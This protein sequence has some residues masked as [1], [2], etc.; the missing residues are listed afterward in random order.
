MKPVIKKQTHYHLLLLR[1]DR[2]VLS[3]RVGNGLVRWL[4]ILGLCLA[5]FGSLGFAAGYHFWKENAGLHAQHQ[6]NEI[7]LARTRLQLEQ[8]S[9]V[10]SLLTATNTSVPLPK[11]EEVSVPA[12]V[13]QEASFARMNGTANATAVANA[14][15]ATARP[16][17]GV[18]ATTRLAS[19]NATKTVSATENANATITRVSVGPT[20]ISD[21]SSPVRVNN[22]SSRPSGQTTMRI[23]YEL[24][25]AEPDTPIR[26]ST[27][28]AAVF[29][30][31]TVRE[32]Q[33]LNPDDTRFSISRMKNMDTAARLTSGK[34]LTGAAFIRITVETEDGKS[35]QGDF[36]LPGS[37]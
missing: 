15:N 8:L 20:N 32:L 33:P 4:I 31:G 30:D 1:D 7:E 18:N 17:A 28:Y 5:V 3:M 2:E 34:S 23:R 11:N 9:N 27:R 21:A 14:H 36:P 19:A 6:Q 10:K 12:T 26:G 37:E 35:F 25:V 22:F 29:S 13:P 16:E 24:V